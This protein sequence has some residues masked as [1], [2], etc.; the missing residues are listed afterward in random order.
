MDKKMGKQ[1][2]DKKATNKDG[3]LAKCVSKL[4]LV[5]FQVAGESLGVS[6]TCMYQSW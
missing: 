2:S 5:K 1:N 4:K 6:I 3:Y